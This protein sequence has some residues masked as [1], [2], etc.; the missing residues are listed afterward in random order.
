ML[1]VSDSEIQFHKR[2]AITRRSLVGNTEAGVAHEVE[3]N[4][5]CVGAGGAAFGGR[6]S[7]TCFGLR[8]EYTCAKTLLFLSVS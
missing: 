1:A 8:Y 6:V 4:N 7:P 3:Y 2:D 5:A